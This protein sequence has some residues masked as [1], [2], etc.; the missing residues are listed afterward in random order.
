MI[1][2]KKVNDELRTDYQVTFVNNASV[3]MS[4]IIKRPILPN[5]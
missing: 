4:I 1:G 5:Q 3:T 2:D